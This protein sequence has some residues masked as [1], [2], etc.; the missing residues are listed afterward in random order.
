[1]VLQLA[2]QNTLVELVEINQLDQVGELGVSVIQGEECLPIILARYN[3]EILYLLVVTQGEHKCLWI[4]L[5]VTEQEEP[6]HET[7]LFDDA[8]RLL[9][10]DTAMEPV[11]SAVNH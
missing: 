3:L 8:V 5:A 2:G 6:I 4:A 11:L 10:G 9:S 1:M 7:L